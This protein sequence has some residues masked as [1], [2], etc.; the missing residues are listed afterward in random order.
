MIVVGVDPDSTRYGLA[1]WENG[2]LIA[3]QSFGF[4]EVMQ[5]LDRFPGH[6]YAVEDVKANKFIYARNRKGSAAMQ[7]QIAQSVGACKH[8]QTVLCDYMEYKG[9][10]PILV[11]PQRGNWAKNRALFE[12]VTG[13]TKQSNEDTRSAAFIAWLAMGNKNLRAV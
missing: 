13:W 7:L 1:I 6:I 3:L 12:R 8:A 9:I 2:K 4:I 11:K 10:D 5:Y